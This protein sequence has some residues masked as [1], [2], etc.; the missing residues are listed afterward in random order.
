M[1]S[2]RRFPPSKGN[3]TTPALAQSNGVSNLDAFALGAPCQGPGGV[4]QL[5]P[6]L[7]LRVECP[8]HSYPA[9]NFYQGSSPG[10]NTSN[11]TSYRAL[12]LTPRALYA[13][14]PRSI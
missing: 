13:S 9:V 8:A 10:Q 5:S 7:H 2:G 6:Y 11:E 1:P 14:S 12:L 4:P 3:E